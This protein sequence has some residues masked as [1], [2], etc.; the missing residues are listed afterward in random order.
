MDKP[1]KIKTTILIIVGILLLVGGFVA[2]YRFGQ[3]DNIRE[4][5]KC[6][7]PKKEEK[8]EPEKPT[9]PEKP[10][11]PEKKEEVKLSK[12]ETLI[13]IYKEE[14]VKKGLLKKDYLAEQIIEGVKYYGYDKNNSNLKYYVIWGKFKCNKNE[15]GLNYPSCVYQSQ[16]DDPD[17]N[18]YYTWVVQILMDETDG[19]FDLKDLGELFLTDEV[20]VKVDQVLE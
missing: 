1:K 7:E 13:N 4:C 2:G 19:R 15:P 11:E 9:E 5:K 3:E 14:A 10:S 18:G 12:K 8:K 17:S 16:L 20:I 6:E